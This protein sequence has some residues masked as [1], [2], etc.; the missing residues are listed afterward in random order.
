LLSR[1]RV[2]TLEPLGK[3]D[4]LELLQ[5]G[6]ADL[7]ARISPRTFEPEEEALSLIAGMSEG[8]GRRALGM[9]EI[10]TDAALADAEQAATESVA[11]GTETVRRVIQRHLV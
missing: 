7:S 4:V 1:C 9:L 5:R 3:D 6:V 8:D 11:L 10:A 2:F